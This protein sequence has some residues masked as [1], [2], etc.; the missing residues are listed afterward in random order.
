MLRVTS[1]FLLFV[2]VEY[3]DQF[4]LESDFD[5][6]SKNNVG[7]AIINQK[8]AQRSERR[9]SDKLKSLKTFLLYCHKCICFVVGLD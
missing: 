2:I 3:H 6:I 1:L 9:T 4:M 7:R 8:Y 5:H